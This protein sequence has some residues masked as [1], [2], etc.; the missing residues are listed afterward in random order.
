MWPDSLCGVVPGSPESEIPG[1]QIGD[2]YK[3]VFPN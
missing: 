1:G 3:Q 2:E